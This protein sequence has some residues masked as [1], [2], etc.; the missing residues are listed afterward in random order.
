MQKH[1]N[2][3]QALYYGEI[4]PYEKNFS[5]NPE[6]V[7]CVNAVADCEAKLIACLNAEQ[8]ELLAQLTDAEDDLSEFSELAHF[9][10][11][12][13][14]GSAFMLDTFVIPRKSAVSENC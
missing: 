14:L 2:I 6:F 12:F 13:R 11:G 1:T 9:V 5:R 4:A 7:K 3:L 8:R 10:E